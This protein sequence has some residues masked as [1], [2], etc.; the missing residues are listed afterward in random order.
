MIIN[1][2]INPR[3]AYNKI[4]DSYY[5]IN[6]QGDLFKADNIAA[7]IWEKLI[8]GMD[9]LDLINFISNIYGNVNRDLIEK[10]VNDFLRSLNESNIFFDGKRQNYHK[11]LYIKPS[12]YIELWNY[13]GMNN[14]PLK[15]DIEVTNS[16][17]LQCKYCYIESKSKNNQ[18]NLS[19]NYLINLFDELKKMGTLFITITGG[20]A[21]L[22]PDIFEI[23]EYAVDKKFYVRLLTN[24]T[25]L[26]KDKIEKLNSISKKGLLA[27]DISVHSLKQREFDN[28]T[29]C[30]GSYRKF[31]NTLELINK[32]SD[33]PIALIYNI[34]KYNINE[35]DEMQKFCQDNNY[36][37]IINPIIY[38]KIY[39]GNN[40]FEYFINNDA[41]RFLIK[42]NLYTPRHIYCYATKAKCWIDYNGEVNLCE[43][44]RISGGNIKRITF[45]EIWGNITKNQ[46]YR[47]KLYLDKECT[48]CKRKNSCPICPGLASHIK[49]KKHF[50]NIASLSQAL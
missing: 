41:M 40:N 46:I 4:N 43:F 21:L 29:Q 7:V 38:P 18:I 24:G 45:N 50:C 33:F 9:I 12:K 27:V 25:N 49:D 23:M 48:E 34:T 26:N 5:I 44:L 1:E 47:D 8:E 30:K 3:L 35:L 31:R 28:F 15:V 22:H 16:C 2:G 32:F 10:D 42:K 14:I 37:L 11:N 20:E 13:A 19:K 36:Y 17:N 6:S 39:N